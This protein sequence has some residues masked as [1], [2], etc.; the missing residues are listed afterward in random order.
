MNQQDKDLPVSWAKSHGKGRF[1]YTALGDWE[2]TWKNPK[3]KTHL[4]KGIQWAM[5]ETAR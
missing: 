2:P 1:F 3:Y 4:I 5:G